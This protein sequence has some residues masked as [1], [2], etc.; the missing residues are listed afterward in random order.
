VTTT[1]CKEKRKQ[2]TSV[3][4]LSNSKVFTAQSPLYNSKVTTPSVATQGLGSV[5]WGKDSTEDTVCACL[6]K[7]EIK[8]GENHAQSLSLILFCSYTFF[9]FTQ[10]SDGTKNC[11]EIPPSKSC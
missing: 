11:K 1:Y 8:K 4:T 5:G 10:F 7:R 2:T 9:W 3:L 6:E